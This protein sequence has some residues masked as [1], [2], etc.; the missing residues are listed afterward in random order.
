[1]PKRITKN[2]SIIIFKSTCT[3]LCKCILISVKL[4]SLSTPMVNLKWDFTRLIALKDIS[5]A[6]DDTGI[7]SKILMMLNIA[8]QISHGLFHEES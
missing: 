5:L 1:M 8:G 3:P 6:A 4:D 7:V 2:S